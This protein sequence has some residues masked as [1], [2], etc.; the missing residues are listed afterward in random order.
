LAPVRGVVSAGSAVSRGF[1]AERAVPAV[2]A[3]RF[4]ADAAAL[5]RDD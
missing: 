5:A 3:R 1:D 4:R 2:R